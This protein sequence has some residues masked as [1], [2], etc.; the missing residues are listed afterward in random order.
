MSSTTPAA[1]VNVYCPSGDSEFRGSVEAERYASD[2]ETR[3]CPACGAAPV[4]VE[5]PGRPIP[6]KDVG[7]LK[8]SERP[9]LRLVAG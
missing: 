7:R 9:T 5:I 4:R 3:R 1:H 8:A 6:R 2:A